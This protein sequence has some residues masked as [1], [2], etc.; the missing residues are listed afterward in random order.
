MQTSDK[1]E[2][3]NC[4]FFFSILCVCTHKKPTWWCGWEGVGTKQNKY[5][6]KKMRMGWIIYHSAC[7]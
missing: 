6:K 7:L 2:K 1:I 3:K 5:N 4:Y